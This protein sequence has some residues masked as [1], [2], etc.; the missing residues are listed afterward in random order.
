MRGFLTVLIILAVSTV[1]FGLA[2][3]A[4]CS[5]FMSESPESPHCSLMQLE[6]KSGC[7]GGKGCAEMCKM[8]DG[9]EPVAPTEDIN[10]SPASA[11]AREVTE[12]AVE[13]DCLVILAEERLHNPFAEVGSA[14]H[15]IFLLTSSLL[16]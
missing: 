16:I 8:A 2:G 4:V 7:I 15:K 13:V 12:E 11:L 1:Q 6:Q 9:D 5:E 10:N 3:A 14:S